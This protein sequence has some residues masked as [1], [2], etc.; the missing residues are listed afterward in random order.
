[1]EARIVIVRV[2]DGSLSLRM[3]LR[4]RLLL[5]LLV[6]ILLL[7]LVLLLILLLGLLLLLITLMLLILRPIMAFL[8]V[9][10]GVDSFLE[11]VHDE[12]RRERDSRCR[13]RLSMMSNCVYTPKP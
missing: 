3:E 10:Q 13:A 4:L 2:L 5:L 11:E 8:K 9:L 7:V 1:M 6:L 12:R